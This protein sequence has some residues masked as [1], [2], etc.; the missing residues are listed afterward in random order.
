MRRSRCSGGRIAAEN[1]QLSLLWWILE[2]VV[3]M[4]QSTTVLICVWVSW[5]QFWKYDILAM[6]TLP[7]ASF[8]EPLDLTLLLTSHSYSTF[9]VSSGWP[10]GSMALSTTKRSKS[11]DYKQSWPLRCSFSVAA[12]IFCGVLVHFQISP[13]DLEIRCKQRTTGPLRY[14]NCCAGCDFLRRRLGCISD[15]PALLS[16]FLY[17]RASLCL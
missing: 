2:K 4:M 9:L 17:Q 8:I 5:N 15:S 16:S 14:E 12:R 1:G 6:S 3:A 10:H 13:R 7:E 11:Q